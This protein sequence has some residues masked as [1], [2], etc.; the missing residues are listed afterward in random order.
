MTRILKNASCLIK[1]RE[2]EIGF[3]DLFSHYPEGMTK[4]GM[5]TLNKFAEGALRSV[6][7]LSQNRGQDVRK[8]VVS[9]NGYLFLGVACYLNSLMG[10]EAYYDKNNRRIEAFHDNYNRPIQCF[11][12]FIWNLR[13][14]AQ[15]LP[16]GFPRKE[17]FSQLIEEKICPY[18][19]ESRNSEDAEKFGKGIPQGY[20][21]AVS[22][23]EYVISE[24]RDKG[25]INDSIKDR[26]GVFQL[27]DN[28]TI[29]SHVIDSAIHEGKEISLCT[30]IAMG[31][32]ESIFM[33]V[34]SDEKTV[35]G[36][37]PHNGRYRAVND[38]LP[39]E[40]NTVHKQSEQR[41][42]NYGN[43]S[44]RTDHQKM[45]GKGVDRDIPREEVRFKIDT[46]IVFRKIKPEEMIGY[47]KKKGFCISTS[48][49]LGTGTVYTI[50]LNGYTRETVLLELDAFFKEKN[51]DLTIINSEK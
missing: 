50:T 2:N 5:N 28:D 47:F 27:K 7:R 30:N 39:K 18:W 35:T 38:E 41:D 40:T 1:T 29:L 45:Q 14:P 21:Y 36:E 12:G 16:E 11:I 43:Q 19:F 34:T 13:E 20:E 6:E 23:E 15:Q 37:W 25:S 42:Y 4:I 17:S 10:K 33:N 51:G 32:Q 8:V 44:W 46:R 31:Y 22:L 49:H 48:S 9:E 24:N 26:V 3:P